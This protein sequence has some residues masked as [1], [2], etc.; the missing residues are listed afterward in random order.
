M[1]NLSEVIYQPTIKT[2]EFCGF[3]FYVLLENP[4]LVLRNQVLSTLS[5]ACYSGLI[6]TVLKQI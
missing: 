6:V 2:A 3:Y 1:G 5:R 4:V